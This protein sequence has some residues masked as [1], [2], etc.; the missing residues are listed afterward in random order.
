[1]MQI[2]NVVMACWAVS[3]VNGFVP[4]GIRSFTFRKQSTLNAGLVVGDAVIA[5]VDDILGSVSD[6]RV[7]FLVSM[8]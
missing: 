7:S 2:M 4:R 3:A 5:E 1:M 6:P 8:M